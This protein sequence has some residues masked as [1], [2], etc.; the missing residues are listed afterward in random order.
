MLEQGTDLKATL[1]KLTVRYSDQGPDNAPVVIFIHGFPFNRSMWDLQVKDLQDRFRV[2]TYDVRGHGDSETGE[3]EFS[4][5][6]FSKDLLALM[7]FLKIPQAIIC[8]LSMGGY[9][10]LQTVVEHPGRIAGLI[11]CDTQCTADTP[12]IIEKRMAT[13]E[14]IRLKGVET[15]AEDSIKKLFAPQSLKTKQ[16][17]VA[18]VKQ[19]ILDTDEE[20]LYN[21]LHA[22]ARR[23]ETCDQ[24]HLIK[25]PVLVLVGAED[26]I[27][28]PSS[29]MMLHH[30]IKNAGLEIIEDA[31]HVS[32]IEQPEVFNEK[33]E[34][35]MLHFEK[36]VVR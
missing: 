11:L 9:I 29:A 27:T 22:L 4:I 1:N 30:G 21:T 35:F 7:D 8:G 25:V 31:G 5:D 10:A 16:S 6:L 28:P 2:V 36:A 14:A 20:T 24:L 33:M 34:K 13:I 15:Y 32:N 3:E 19:M 12:E 17:N 23:R 18:Y 26:K